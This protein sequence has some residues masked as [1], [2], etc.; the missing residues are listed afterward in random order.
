MIIYKMDEADLRMFKIDPDI[1][2]LKILKY[3]I[4]RLG[5]FH[6]WND[7]LILQSVEDP[8]LII[9]IKNKVLVKIFKQY[10][11]FLWKMAKP[12]KLKNLRM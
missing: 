12:V 10:F 4:N 9:E 6:I 2:E 8:P 1:T 5:N 7:A 11:D 3:D